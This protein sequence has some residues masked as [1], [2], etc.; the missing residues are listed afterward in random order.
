MFSH[1]L[2]KAGYILTDPKSAVNTYPYF[3]SNINR[4]LQRLGTLPINTC[5]MY[6]YLRKYGVTSNREFCPKII[7]SVLLGN[8]A[9]MLFSYMYDFYFY[10]RELN[11]VFSLVKKSKNFHIFLQYVPPNIVND[12]TYRRAMTSAIASV[13]LIRRLFGITGK[14]S[15][16]QVFDALRYRK[17]DI[18]EY[19]L[20]FHGTERWD[21]L[22]KLTKSS[23]VDACSYAGHAL[24]PS[25]VR[26]LHSVYGKQLKGIEKFLIDFMIQRRDIQLELYRFL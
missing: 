13:D 4:I 6:D 16:M 3:K 26:K 9:K 22:V 1:N 23:L 15:D 24:T 8:R 10:E 7:V 14:F 12:E 17:M 18:L 5:K 20:Q 25:M 19:I 21:S 11:T 2:Y